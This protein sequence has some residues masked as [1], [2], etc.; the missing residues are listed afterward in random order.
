MQSLRWLISP[1]CLQQ[2]FFITCFVVAKCSFSFLFLL[3]FFL[4]RTNPMMWSFVPRSCWSIGLLIF[5]HCHPLQ[6]LTSDCVA[7][8]GQGCH[9][10]WPLGP[11]PKVK[12]WFI[13]FCFSS[14]QLLSTLAWCHKSNVILLSRGIKGGSWKFALHCVE[15]VCITARFRTLC[16]TLL[17]RASN[18]LVSF[19]RTFQKADQ[20][21][22]PR[23]RVI[24]CNM[25]WQRER[26]QWYCS[27]PRLTARLFPLEEI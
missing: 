24:R 20:L 22:E 21:K 25:R 7:E 3:C 1:I 27:P 17:T 13:L 15:V 10:E 19:H 18:S 6:K 4:W 16:N 23:L 11:W 14:I 12:S 8:S 9:Q 5:E 26:L 2:P